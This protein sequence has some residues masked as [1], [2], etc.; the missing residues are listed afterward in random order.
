MS[1]TLAHF[2]LSLPPSLSL[3]LSQTS[4][5]T[6][7]GS[8]L[9]KHVGTKGCSDKRNVQITEYHRKSS[10][11]LLMRGCGQEISQGCM[12]YFWIRFLVF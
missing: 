12:C 9:F 2:F 10:Y 8:Q 5:E 6:T 1:Y 7:V 11:R 3:S 4:L